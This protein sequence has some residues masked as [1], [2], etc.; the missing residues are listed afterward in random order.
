MCIRDR[1]KAG[2]ASRYEKIVEMI[3]ESEKLKSSVEGRAEK[4]ADRLVP[5]TFAGT[6]LTWLLTRN[7]AKALAVLMVD[8][9][10]YTHLIMDLIAYGGAALGVILAATQFRAGRVDLAGCIMIVLLAAD[11]FL[12][13]RLLGSFFHI[14]MNGICLLYTSQRTY[15]ERIRRE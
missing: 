10:S 12:P 2:G 4:L 3:E 14:A 6:A 9:V 5:V 11:F 8:S 15:Q 13:M 7:I 1:K